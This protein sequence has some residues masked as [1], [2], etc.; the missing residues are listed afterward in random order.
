M[1]VIFDLADSC[2]IT[3]GCVQDKKASKER[4]REE[5]KQQIHSQVGGQSQRETEL[6]ALRAQL[7]KDNFSI[8]DIPSDGNCLYRYVSPPLLPL[9]LINTDCYLV[10]LLVD[11]QSYCRPVISHESSSFLRANT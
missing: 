8:K 7:A 6:Q 11:S 10:L 3:Y 5:V 1:I 2:I 4:E 9:V